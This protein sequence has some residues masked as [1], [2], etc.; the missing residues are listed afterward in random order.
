M[1]LLSEPVGWEE[2]QVPAFSRS[3]AGG[4]G[5]GGEGVTRG[6]AASHSSQARPAALVLAGASVSPS[7][8]FSGSGMGSYTPCR[9]PPCA[10]RKLFLG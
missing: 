3:W 4:G 10:A 8:A 7:A 9:N 6:I 2:R 5:E 1:S